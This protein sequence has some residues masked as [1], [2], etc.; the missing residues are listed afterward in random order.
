[1]LFR[2]TA[3]TNA[4][5]KAARAAQ[6]ALAAGDI[7]AAGA[8]KRNQLLG[9]QAARVANDVLKEVQRGLRKLDTFN[10]EGT[11]KNIDQDYLDQIDTLLENVDLSRSTTKREIAKRKSLAQ[12]IEAQEDAGLPQPEVD[13]DVLANMRKTH[14]SEMTVSEFRSLMD[15]VQNIEHLGQIGRAHV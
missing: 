6:T 7:I 14:Y 11:R 12:W 8:A 13:Q 9:Q 4:E 15:A 2:S 5:G 3:F 1:M 10:K